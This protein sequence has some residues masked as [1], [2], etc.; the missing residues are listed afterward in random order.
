[1]IE[2]SVMKGLTA[3]L[4]QHFGKWMLYS[5]RSFLPEHA[6]KE[7]KNNKKWNREEK[8]QPNMTKRETKGVGQLQCPKSPQGFEHHDYYTY[9]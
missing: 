6:N 8:L 1:M 2:A 9:E 4:Q 7:R 3:W 5:K